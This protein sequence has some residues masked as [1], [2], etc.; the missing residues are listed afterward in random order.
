MFVKYS[1]KEESEVHTFIL[2]QNTAGKK[3]KGKGKGKGKAKE[4]SSSHQNSSTH[5]QDADKEIE[6][7][8]LYETRFTTD[9]KYKDL[10]RLCEN[11]TI[12][13]RYHA[14]YFNLPYDR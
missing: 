13:K 11:G 12:P 8:V 3:G 7:K 9:D 4:I 1:M 10:K 2:H 5:N 6:L 14:E